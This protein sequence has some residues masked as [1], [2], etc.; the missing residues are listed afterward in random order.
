MLFIILVF[1]FIKVEAE[2]AEERLRKSGKTKDKYNLFEKILTLE[3]SLVIG[4]IADSILAGL[5]SVI[6]TLKQFLTYSLFQLLD[7]KDV[8]INF[9]FFINQ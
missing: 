7:Y 5:D 3:K 9:I 8:G 6:I 1:S 2:K 4:T